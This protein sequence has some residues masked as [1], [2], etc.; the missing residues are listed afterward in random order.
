M[1]VRSIATCV[2]VALCLAGPLQPTVA[3]A[4]DKPGGTDG[5]D[6]GAAIMTVA[7]APFKG[8]VCLLGGVAGAALFVAT[9]G[10]ADRES[11]AVVREGCDLRWIV[12]GD[13]IRPDRSPSYVLRADPDPEARTR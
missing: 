8:V 6:V 13:D 3:A 7:G 11:A 2:T 1:S 5:Y 4:Q 9:F 10:N 12:R